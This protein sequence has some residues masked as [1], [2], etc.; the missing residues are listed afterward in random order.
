MWF[1]QLDTYEIWTQ[2]HRKTN[3]LFHSG[4]KFHA[5]ESLVTFNNNLFVRARDAGYFVYT[6]ILT[7]SSYCNMFIFLENIASIL[8]GFTLYIYFKCVLFILSKKHTALIL[9]PFLILW[10]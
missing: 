8:N 10:N 5:Y 6:K 3:L 7:K 9:I 1:C 4:K 2:R